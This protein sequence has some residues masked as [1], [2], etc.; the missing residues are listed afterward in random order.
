MSDKKT[1]F[2][3]ILLFVLLLPLT[4]I[5]AVSEE[6][7]TSHLICPCEC[8][9][10]ISTCD[11]PT[12]T[13]VKK[14]INSMK[15]N[16]FSEKQVLKALQTEYSE[17]ILAHPEKAN[18]VPLWMAGIP[19]VLMLVFFGYIMSRKPNP[20]IIPDKEKYEKRF[21]DEYREFVSETEEM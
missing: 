7:M 18:S 1:V 8:T 3:A 9:M 17:A 16:G 21:E 13:Q 10:I 11:C 19:L 2:R 12:A 15:E 20:D 5:N 6:D 14:E 4:S